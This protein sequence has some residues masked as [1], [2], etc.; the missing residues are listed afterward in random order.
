MNRYGGPPQNCLGRVNPTHSRCPL[1]CW[2]GYYHQLT[3][4][5]SVTSNQVYHDQDLT[6]DGNVNHCK[7]YNCRVTINR[8]YT[9]FQ[10]EFHKCSKIAADVVDCYVEMGS[11][12]FSH[13]TANVA[14]SSGRG[15][16]CL[17]D[18]KNV[19][20]V[21]SVIKTDKHPKVKTA[22]TSKN[23][24]KS[25]KSYTTTTTSTSFTMASADPIENLVSS[26]MSSVSNGDMNHMVTSNGGHVSHVFC[27]NSSTCISGDEGFMNGHPVQRDSSGNWVR[28]SY[29]KKKSPSTSPIFKKKTNM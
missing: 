25:Y 21:Q 27:S 13:Y 16:N 8:P 14:Y 9:A 18:C 4:V 3:P 6:F 17:R 23:P 24:K 2:A 29:K 11:M 10:C 20:I 19:N 12:K 7:F 5:M 1:F 22:K 28:K 26:I 15:E